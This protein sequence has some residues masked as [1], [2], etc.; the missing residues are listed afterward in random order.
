MSYGK[1]DT[2]ADTHPSG[3]PNRTAVNADNP[4][5]GR[6]ADPIPEVSFQQAAVVQSEKHPRE[7]VQSPL[8]SEDVA[9][10]IASVIGVNPNEAVAS[11]APYPIADLPNGG[12]LTG[13]ANHLLIET[14][15]NPPTVLLTPRRASDPIGTASPAPI[16]E[17]PV[18][19]NS[20][21][22]AQQSAEEIAA[23]QGTEQVQDSSPSAEDLDAVAAENAAKEATSGAQ[24]YEQFG[25][26]QKVRFTPESGNDTT[27]IYTIETWSREPV[28]GALLFW[29]LEEIP[30]AL[31][32]PINL[33]AVTAAE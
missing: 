26:G 27:P 8:L 5:F 14:D 24:D 21:P 16:N 33:E 31:F 11:P 30:G 15:G 10:G 7:T 13:K 22:L 32:L 17:E 18:V 23:V 25:P 9:E 29:K 4:I 28:E 20:E 3:H 1:P 12:T 19:D 2:H 6:P